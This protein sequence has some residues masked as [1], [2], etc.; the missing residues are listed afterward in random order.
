MGQ[1]YA[2]LC[3]IIFSVR[4]QRFLQLI[5]TFSDKCH[6][7]SDYYL[8]TQIKK[9]I[10]NRKKNTRHDQNQ[11]KSSYSPEFVRSGILFYC[12]F[13]FAFILTSVSSGSVHNRNRSQAR[14]LSVAD[15]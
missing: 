2:N 14:P 11:F 7:N 9:K 13:I 5:G 1:W 15:K 12:L 3:G 10:A 8:S 4:C 6:L